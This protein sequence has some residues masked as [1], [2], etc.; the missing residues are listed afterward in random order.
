VPTLRE[1]GDGAGGCELIA[2]KS[3]RDAQQTIGIN[4]YSL[5]GGNDQSYSLDDE[6]SPCVGGYPNSP[7]SIFVITHCRA[8]SARRLGVVMYLLYVVKSNKA[9]LLLVS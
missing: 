8:V 9:A 3:A 4:A 5:V 6:V 2:M 1:V 7:C